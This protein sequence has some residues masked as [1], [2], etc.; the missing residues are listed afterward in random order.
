MFM[1]A[2]VVECRQ[3]PEYVQQALAEGSEFLFFLFLGVFEGGE[4][5]SLALMT[6]Q[7]TTTSRSIFGKLACKIRRTRCTPFKL[8]GRRIMDAVMEVLMR[9][10]GGRQ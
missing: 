7:K 9:S 2:T 10:W 8:K 4:K 1:V 6:A 3:T 5:G